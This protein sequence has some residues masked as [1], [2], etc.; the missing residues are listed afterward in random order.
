MKTHLGDLEQ[1][2]LRVQ[3]PATADGEGAA[4]ALALVGLADE[5]Q[6]ARLFNERQA[7][8][9]LRSARCG[10]QEVSGMRSAD[11]GGRETH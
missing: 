10:D 11:G 5:L 9:D 3:V 2:L 7:F 6:A 8:S 1:V 4:R